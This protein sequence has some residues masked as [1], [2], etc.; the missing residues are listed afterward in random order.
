MKFD[1]YAGLWESNET[2]KPKDSDPHADL[3]LEYDFG[4]VDELDKAIISGVVKGFFDE[5]TVRS[6]GES[7]NHNLALSDQ[8]NAYRAAWRVYH[9]S[10]EDNAEEII[11]S[12]VQSIRS[13]INVVDI[14][15][16]DAVVQTLR[17]LGA[18]EKAAE[19]I[20]FY[21]DNKSGDATIWDTESY[22]YRGGI[23]DAEVLSACNEK[24]RLHEP[25]TTQKEVLLKVGISQGW[26]AK[27]DALLANASTENI[28]HILKSVRGETRSN[29]ISAV[30]LYLSIS[31]PS[32]DVKKIQENLD[33]ALREIA[34]ENALNRRRIKGVFGI[35][36]DINTSS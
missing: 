20:R 29:V 31:N 8:G 25:E 23:K 32:A 3:L 30:R 15:N 4:N 26:N 17:E 16:L 5:E 34:G 33:F 9:D 1:P 27:D 28:K 13:N 14:S 19:L 22:S 24:L 7:V 11:E 21:V 36:A 12:L 6:F 10:Y 35:D 18:N 2:S